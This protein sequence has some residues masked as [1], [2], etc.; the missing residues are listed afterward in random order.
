MLQTRSAQLALDEKYEA[1]T[2]CWEIFMSKFVETDGIP[3]EAILND[4]E[5]MKEIHD[6]VEMLK[7]GS[8]TKCIYDDLKKDNM[9]FS[10][11]TRRVI[12]EMGNSESFKLRHFS[13]YTVSFVLE[14]LARTT[15][16]LSMW[17]MSST[18]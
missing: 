8:R 3:Q 13:D 12:H 16:I 1:L 18:R 11:E 7:D 6:K 15:K 2:F 10:E 14:T 4:K 17:R 5:H 9:I